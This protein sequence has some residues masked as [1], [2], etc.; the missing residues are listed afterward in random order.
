[1]SLLSRAALLAALAAVAACDGGAQQP[2]HQ[3]AA[4]AWHEY[5]A[6][7]R[8]HGVPDM[9][10]ATIDDQGRADFPASAP[11]VPG[12]AVQA[13]G[14]GVASLPTRSSPPPDVAAL[15]RF[16][17][18]MRAQGV[19]EWPDPSPDGRFPLT[20]DLLDQWKGGPRWP[21]IEAAWHGPCRQYDPSGQVPLA[22]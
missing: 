3:G 15:A 16:S 8:T 4:A 11:Q 21:L 2:V 14:A 9:P 17:H 20:P 6:C 7:V 5:V 13:C 12:D 22:T 18:C 19:A 1:M 10:D